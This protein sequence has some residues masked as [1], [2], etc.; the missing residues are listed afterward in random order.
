M[1]VKEDYTPDEYSEFDLVEKLDERVKV[2]KATSITGGIY[3]FVLDQPP[4]KKINGSDDV[5][6]VASFKLQV[7]ESIEDVRQAAIKAGKKYI[8]D[9]EAPNQAT[10]NAN[11]VDSLPDPENVDEMPMFQA[12]YKAN[13][14]AV[15]DWVEDNSTRTREVHGDV[16]IEKEELV[17]NMTVMA[18]TIMREQ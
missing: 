16:I 15:N 6:N 1:R 8:E 13:K 7:N 4:F 5:E 12:F 17:K 18:M 14:A 11:G 10:H 3:F 2:I 9:G